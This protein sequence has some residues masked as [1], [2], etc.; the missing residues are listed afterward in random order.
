MFSLPFAYLDGHVPP[1]KLLELFRLDLDL[2]STLL[3]P[4]AKVIKQFH[5]TEV[6]SAW[7]K[8]QVQTMISG[9]RPSQAD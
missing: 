9:L 4:R 2:P 5:T 1:F 3:L 7:A 8:I 6:K